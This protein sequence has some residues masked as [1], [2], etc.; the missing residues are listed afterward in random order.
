MENIPNHKDNELEL[1]FI[2]INCGL[3]SK[4]VKSAKQKGVSGGTIF[5]GKGISQNHLLKLL[6]L[7]DVKREIAILI[8]EKT[9][10]NNALEALN[11]EFA[12]NK[13]HHGIAF[14]MPVS[15]LFGT[16]NNNCYKINTEGRGENDTMHKAIFVIVDKGKA[17]SVID[18]AVKAGARGGTII[19]S[20]GSGIHETSKLFSMEIEPEREIVLIV[21]E[22]KLVESIITSIRTD[23]KL[24][25]PGNGIMFTIDVNQA[26][27][28]Y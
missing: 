17:E 23:I 18:S 5:L 3:A 21:A 2:I 6:D 11:K 15:G 10:A 27:G 28:L 1:L 12:F 7:S 16:R 9:V 24:D 25:E 22:T 26:Y 8:G 13:P 20:R 4:V 14:S 19:N